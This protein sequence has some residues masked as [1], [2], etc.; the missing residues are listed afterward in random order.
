MTKQQIK[1]ELN[2]LLNFETSIIKLSD[3]HNNIY[4]KKEDEIPFSF[5]GNKVRIAAK[6]FL[7]LIEKDHDIV[8]TY[9]ASSSNLC[10]VI[11]NM[12]AR[13]GIKCVII[14]PEDNYLETP[15]SKMVNFLGTE[16]V[17]CPITKVKQTIDNVFSHYQATNKPYF[18][19]GGGHG[20]NGTEAYR[21]VFKQITNFEKNNNLTFD[22][23]FITL[24]T[25]TSMSGLIV[26]NT[27]SKSDKKIVGISIAR[28]L[29]QAQ[30]V[31]CEALS[32]YNIS[33]AN[34]TITDQYRCGGY[35]LYN[36]SVTDTIKF[37]LKYNGLNLD[38][39]YTGKSFAGMKDF[40][41]EKKISNKN[42]LFIHTGG[43][44]LF[45][46]NN[47]YFLEE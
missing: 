37:Q 11:A 38:T 22:Y 42:I 23:I 29:N 30:K 18:I 47:C 16:I 39:T 31:M 24:A 12:A 33:T 15:N 14:S 10:R 2:F 17:K 5:G 34:Y 44:P 32:H 13:Y 8:I 3:D 6:Y 25:G 40:L 7:E 21:C 1:D 46:K 45:F 41:N 4:I 19:Y 36:D 20:I 35:G 9:G 43:T 26:E 28:E 27:L